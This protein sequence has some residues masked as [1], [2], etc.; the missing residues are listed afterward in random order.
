M[1]SFTS[2]FFTEDERIHPSNTDRE[3]LYRSIFLLMTDLCLE[4]Y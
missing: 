2:I 1:T 3:G 4:P